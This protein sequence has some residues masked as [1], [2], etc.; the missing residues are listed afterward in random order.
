MAFWQKLVGKVT[1]TAKTVMTESVMADIADIAAALAPAATGAAL[2]GVSAA[3]CKR[4]GNSRRPAAPSKAS[5]TP[6]MMTQTTNYYFMD[7]D[8]K[9]ELIKKLTQQ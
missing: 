3:I 1:D 8:A 6:M 2:I 5:T 4:V 7:D 9:A